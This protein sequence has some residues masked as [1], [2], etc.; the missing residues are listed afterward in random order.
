MAY[1][2]LFEPIKIGKVEIKNRYAYS[3]TN[4]LYQNYT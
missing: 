1:D 3:P 4:F 2:K